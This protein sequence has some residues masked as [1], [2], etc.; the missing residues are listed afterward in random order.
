MPSGASSWAA[1][2]ASW[3]SAAHGSACVG[4]QVIEAAERG[5][6]LVYGAVQPGRVYD[7]GH[8]GGDGCALAD[9][10]PRRA[11]QTIGVAGDEPDRRSLGG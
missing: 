10:V 7:I 3:I 2:A 6:D 4:H 1:V 5:R 8:R 9:E 11:G